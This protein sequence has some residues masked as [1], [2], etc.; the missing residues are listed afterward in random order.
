MAPYPLSSHGGD[1]HQSDCR[2]QN[3]DVTEV[4][5][6]HNVTPFGRYPKSADYPVHQDIRGTLEYYAL[7]DVGHPSISPLDRVMSLI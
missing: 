3:S 2:R 7:R 1:R 4:G 6:Q 5:P